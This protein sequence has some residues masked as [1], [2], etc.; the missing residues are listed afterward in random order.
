MKI[1]YPFIFLLVSFSAAAQFGTISGVVT[2]ADGQPAEH[3][4]IFVKGTGKGGV[5]DAK[6][7]Y[8]IRRV[9]QGANTVTVSFVGFDPKEQTIEVVAGQTVE[10]NFVLNE[11]A[12]QLNEVIVEGSRQN[13]FSKSQSDYVAKVPLKNLENPQV[14][15]TITKELLKQQLV[16][17][18]DDAVRNAPG[19]QR[20]WE[21]TG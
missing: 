1:L 21:A 3:V 2:T 10:L 6:G 19:V 8:E 14:Y 15:T 11:T 17:S 7:R 13:V 4:N 20:M 12:Q 16:Y 9:S 5:T 18:V